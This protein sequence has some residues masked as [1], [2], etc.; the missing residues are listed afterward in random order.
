MT[1]FAHNLLPLPASIKD[2]IQTIEKAHAKIALVVD[3]QRQLL[4]TVTDGDI[5]RAIL[6][7]ISVDTS[8]TK[9]MNTEPH[10]GR[11]GQDKTSFLELRRRNICR[12]IPIV[13]DGGHVV[14]LEALDEPLAAPD[15]WVVLMAGGI[16]N[17]LYPLTKEIPKPML[18][19]GGKPILEGIMESFRAEGYKKFFIALNYLSGVIRNH[20]GDGSRWGVQIE[21]LSESKPLGTAGALSLL[22]EKPTTPII[23]MN[24]DILTRINFRQLVG[25][26]EDSHAQATMA[27][28][29]HL[30]EVPFGVV[31]SEEFRILN[32]T[33]KP[34]QRFLINAGIYVLSPDALD[35][36][37]S[38]EYFDMT[39]L[40]NALTK[41]KRRACVF[42]LREYWLDIGHMED[43]YR[44]QKDFADGA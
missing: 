20:F 16:G 19:I 17:R 34:S 21:Y 22:P 29:E 7:G 39:S 14:A 27:V 37:P 15:N 26:H 18:P 10:T 13:D 2:A 12:H 32:V 6:D 30:M 4:G 8:V 44:A 42:P 31:E 1:D 41:H 9:V 38:D 25:F 33:E 11:L 43:F 28:R 35:V 5:R 23:V 3:D 36:I 24:G 40:F